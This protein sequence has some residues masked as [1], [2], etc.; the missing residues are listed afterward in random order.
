MQ[1]SGFENVEGIAQ[2]PPWGGEAQ[3]D[4]LRVLAEGSMAG[5][6]RVS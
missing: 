6:G 2:V 1:Y 4:L 3:A 5:V